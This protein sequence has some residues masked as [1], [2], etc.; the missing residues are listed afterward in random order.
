MLSSELKSQL[1]D[2]ETRQHVCFVLVNDPICR[3]VIIRTLYEDF[4]KL[5]IEKS[6]ARNWRKLVSISIFITGLLIEEIF[7]NIHDVII[8]VKSWIL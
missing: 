6:S 1:D 7:R 8:K 2:P 4:N 5:D 3:D